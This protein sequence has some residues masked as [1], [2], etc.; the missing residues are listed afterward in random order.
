MNDLPGKLPGVCRGP[1]LA[2]QGELV[3][4]PKRFPSGMAALG[5]FLHSKGLKYGIYSDAGYVPCPH[6]PSPLQYSTPPA[7]HL[8][9]QLF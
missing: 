5:Q 8:H 3:G 7:V 1:L 9:L 2:V 6:L 4:H